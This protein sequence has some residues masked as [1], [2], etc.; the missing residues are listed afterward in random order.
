MA[1]SAICFSVTGQTI[2]VLTVTSSPAGF[3]VFVLIHFCSLYLIKLY[4]C[5]DTNLH[6]AASKNK[7]GR[8]IYGVK[9]TVSYIVKESGTVIMEPYLESNKNL[10]TS[11]GLPLAHTYRVWCRSISAFVSYLADR[12]TDTHR[13]TEW[14]QYLLCL[15][16]HRGNYRRHSWGGDWRYQI[17]TLSREH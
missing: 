9:C 5:G 2:R 17:L 3:L 13:R 4:P 1:L 10:T 14:S 8:P 7:L 16:M 15:Y 6:S 12:Q 11:R